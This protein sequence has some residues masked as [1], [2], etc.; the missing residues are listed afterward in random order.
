MTVSD[1]DA[2]NGRIE[3]QRDGRRIVLIG[4]AHVSAASVHAVRDAIAEIRPDAV[5]VELDSA[6]YG[7]MMSGRSWQDLD[8]RQ[9]LRERK[10]FLLLANL[11]L[12]AFQKRLGAHLEVT[13]GAEMVAAIEACREHQI[14]FV[15]ADRDIQTTL[16][17]AWARA[18]LWGRSKMLAALGSAAL[19]REELDAE[20]VE[21]LKSVGTLRSMLEELA[22][23]LPQAK[24]VLIDERDEWIAE[25]I[26]A[27]A[28]RTIVAVVGAGHVPGIT[29]RLQANPADAT[30]ADDDVEPAGSEMVAADGDADNDDGRSRRSEQ[31]SDRV[32]NTEAVNAGA[33]SDRFRDRGPE[34]RVG[35]SRPDL[36]Q[37]PPRGIVA[38]II[39]WLIPAAVVGLL[40][41]GFLKNGLDLSLTMLSRWVLVNGTLSAIGALVA[42]AHPVTV[43]VAFV[44]APITSMNPTVGVG[45]FTGLI[46][47][48]VRKPRVADFE[49]LADDITSLRG[50]MRNRITHILVVFMLSSIGSIVGT[51]VGFSFLTS[52]LGG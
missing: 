14:R 37:V 27:T 36:A 45:L 22:D 39:P 40:V 4:T 17:R 50:F 5:C 16:R 8:I 21:Q 6:R 7:A 44:G 2:D 10:G 35:T 20:E 29:E 41:A 51:F 18:G 32:A 48:I 24:T 43:I 23:Y 42:L 38:R 34:S 52:L 49:G 33:E 28:G 47:A 31:L 1:Q 3:I 46:E 15:L 12:A 30:S 25:S 11:V 13:P 26:Q 19:S 9:V